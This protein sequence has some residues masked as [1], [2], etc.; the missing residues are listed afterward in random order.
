MVVNWFLRSGLDW[1]IGLGVLLVMLLYSRFGSD[2]G[3]IHICHPSSTSTSKGAGKINKTNP[4][5]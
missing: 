5:G 3:E 4:A 2:A 1:V